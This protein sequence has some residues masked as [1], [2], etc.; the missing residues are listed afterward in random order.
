MFSDLHQLNFTGH[1]G[2]LFLY[3][4][5]ISDKRYNEQVLQ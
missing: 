4:R 1:F 5:Y 3:S 2:V